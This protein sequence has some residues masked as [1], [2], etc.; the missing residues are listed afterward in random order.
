MVR[1]WPFEPVVREL[2]AQL[3]AGAYADLER[4]TGGDRLRAGEIAPAVAAYGRRLVPFPIADSLELDVVRIPGAEPKAWSVDVPLRTKEEGRSD[5]TLQLTVREG[6][7][8]TF[9][10]EIEDLHV[11]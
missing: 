7:S 9:V 5:L 3:A 10:V 11:L 6:R 4:R 2:V 1:T 8:G